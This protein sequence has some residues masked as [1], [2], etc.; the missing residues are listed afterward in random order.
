MKN[1]HYVSFAV[2]YPAAAEKRVSCYQYYYTKH[3]TMYGDPD[4]SSL[5]TDIEM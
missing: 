1:T 2:W 3:S 4:I 5:T